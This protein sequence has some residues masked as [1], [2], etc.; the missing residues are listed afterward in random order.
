MY[1]V[2][3]DSTVFY[4]IES[5]FYK[6]QSFFK[7]TPFIIPSQLCVDV[8]MALHYAKSTFNYIRRISKIQ[9]TL[10]LYLEF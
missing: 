9:L 4:M 2:L 6:V 5:L 1:V 3:V 8:Q 7:L 10:K